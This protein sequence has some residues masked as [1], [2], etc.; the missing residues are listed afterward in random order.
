ME[1]IK[2]TLISAGYIEGVKHWIFEVGC[3]H[4]EFDVRHKLLPGS[5]V[6]KQDLTLIII[7]NQGHSH[8]LNYIGS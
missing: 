1:R 6:L 3:A 5:L 4:C 8:I 7:S 2:F